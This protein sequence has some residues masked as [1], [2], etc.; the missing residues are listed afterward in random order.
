MLKVSL[1]RGTDKNHEQLISHVPQ[2]ASRERRLIFLA[3]IHEEG[4]DAGLQ[5]PKVMLYQKVGD[6]DHYWIRKE[7]SDGR[8]GRTNYAEADAH[9]GVT[10]IGG[11][12]TSVRLMLEKLTK[13]AA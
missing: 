12:E 2:R 11:F 10:A 13:R 6:P 9:D 4:I 3:V 7:N 8:D 5:D 1:F